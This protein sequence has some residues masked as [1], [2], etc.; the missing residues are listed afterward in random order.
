VEEEQDEEE[1]VEEE[2]QEF[3]LTVGSRKGR[4]GFVQLH[5]LLHVSSACEIYPMQLPYGKLDRQL[6]PQTFGIYD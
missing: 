1:P 6:N 2:Q 4:L 5:G 3:L